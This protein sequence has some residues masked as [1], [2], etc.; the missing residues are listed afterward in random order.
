[1]ISHKSEDAINKLAYEEV[2][3]EVHKGRASRFQGQ[4]FMYLLT[5]LHDLEEAAR[6][7]EREEDLS[8]HRDQI[9]VS[10]ES[11]TIAEQGNRLTKALAWA[12]FLAV[13]VALVAFLA[14]RYSALVS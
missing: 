5:R 13:L 6:K 3:A 11:N 2:R 8:L 7:T 1:M 12:A 4:K 14:S 10:A 9:E